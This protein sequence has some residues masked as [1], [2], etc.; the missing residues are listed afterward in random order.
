[1]KHT[2]IWWIGRVLAWLA[3]RLKVAV[4]VYSIIDVQ[5]KHEIGRIFHGRRGRRACEEE[6]FRD[7]HAE[8]ARLVSAHDIRRTPETP[9]KEET[10]GITRADLEA[11]T[12]RWPGW[13]FTA[14]ATQY[15][16]PPRAGWR[17]YAMGMPCRITAKHYT[18]RVEVTVTT[19]WAF[20]AKGAI[21]LMD[22]GLSGA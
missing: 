4:D 8:M 15:E 16:I 7:K 20:T 11:L 19:E 17:E 14:E 10:A 12:A 2:K 22:E 6:V 13:D 1:M 21:A 3:I 9:G 18:G 5:W